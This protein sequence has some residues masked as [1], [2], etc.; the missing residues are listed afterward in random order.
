MTEH[1]GMVRAD[2]T[3][4]SWLSIIITMDDSDSALNSTTLLNLKLICMYKA[5][6]ANDASPTL[7]NSDWDPLMHTFINPSFFAYLFS[8]AIFC[9]P[10]VAQVFLHTIFAYLLLHTSFAGLGASCNAMPWPIERQKWITV[11]K[12][13]SKWNNSGFGFLRSNSSNHYVDK[14]K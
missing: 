14:Q 4:I 2:D 10:F 1:F 5:R 9:T 11:R 8:H 12:T 6:L 3:D 7:V 13:I